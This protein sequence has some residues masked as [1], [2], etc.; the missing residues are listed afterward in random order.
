MKAIGEELGR[1]VE[2]KDM[3]FDALIEAVTTETI[4]VIAAGMTITDEREEQVD[5]TD[6]YFSADQAVLVREAS[7]ISVDDP[8]EIDSA[9]YTI[10]VQNDTTGAIWVDENASSAEIRKYGKYIET[11]QD[12]ENR[13]IDMIVLDKPVA[14]AFAQNRPVKMIKV[15]PTDEKYGLAVKEGDPLLDD[16]N[17]ALDTVMESDTWD[18]LMAEYFGVQ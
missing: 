15:I 17:D 7:N 6:P 13:N 9:D 5:F 11:I 3:D 16:L 12:L 4:D 18:E 8:A 1:E 10:G 14:E 2:V